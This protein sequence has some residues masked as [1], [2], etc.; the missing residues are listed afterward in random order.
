[1]SRPG[2]RV[3]RGLTII[4]LCIDQD[5]GSKQHLDNANL[6]FPS[7]CVQQDSAVSTLL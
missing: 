4:P 5:T 2:S 6:S 3:Q 7:S 1:M